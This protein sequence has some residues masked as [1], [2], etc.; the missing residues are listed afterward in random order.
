MSQTQS[1]ENFDPTEV[2]KF[3][4]LAS[5]WWDPHSEFKPLHDINPLRLQYIDDHVGL[6]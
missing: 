3:E 6:A 4:E 1:A 5:R 2:R